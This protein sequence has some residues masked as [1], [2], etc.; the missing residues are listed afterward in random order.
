M[1]ES[2]TTTTET[3]VGHCKSDAT[4]VYIGRGAGGTAL[5]D[6][7]PQQRGGLGNPHTVEEY[8]REE[9]IERFR[10]EFEAR[11]N[12]D[13]ALREFVASLA[14]DTLG[15]WCRSVDD[16]GPACHGDVIAEWGDRLAQNDG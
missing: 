15:C 16:D 6:V 2:S 9:A 4:D 5:G 13:P 14:G 7:P 1:S 11:L 12:D 3:R 10:A 8:D